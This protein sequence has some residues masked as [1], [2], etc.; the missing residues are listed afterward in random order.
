MVWVWVRGRP[1]RPPGRVLLY[2][3]EH[4]R[5]VGF[6]GVSRVLERVAVLLHGG[7]H[8]RAV[9]PERLSRVT[10]RVAVLLHGGEHDRAVGLE[11]TRRVRERGL[12]RTR[13]VRERV[14]DFIIAID[15]NR[16][17]LHIRFAALTVSQNAHRAG[18]VEHKL[19]FLQPVH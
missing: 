3:G 1:E 4:D 19:A 11:R 14:A 10:E 16:R 12:E 7:E 15:S 2:G 5:G 13:R 6:E 9:G 17:G 8:D 18:T